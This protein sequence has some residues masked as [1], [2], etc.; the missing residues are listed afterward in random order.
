MEVIHRDQTTLL[1]FRYILNNVFWFKRQLIQQNKPSSSLYFWNLILLKL[2]IGCWKFFFNP[3]FTQPNEAIENLYACSFF[4]TCNPSTRFVHSWSLPKRVHIQFFW[5]PR[6]WIGIVSCWCR[7][8]Q[9]HVCFWNIFE[10]F[11]S[12]YFKI[13][14]VYNLL[15]N[16]YLSDWVKTKSMTWYSWFL[17]NQYDDRS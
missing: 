13:S 17:T 4:P 3:I 2:P 7:Y 10:C 16:Q 11:N 12:S 8:R 15:L 6:T 1:L 9:L 5:F 14:Y